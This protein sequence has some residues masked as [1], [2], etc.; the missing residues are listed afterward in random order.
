MID[1]RWTSQP[2]KF[3]GVHVS[4]V[5]FLPV[6]MFASKFLPMWI[7]GLCFVLYSVFLILCKR[8]DMDPIKYLISLEV[9]FIRRGQWLVR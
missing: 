1:W 2:L 6:L 4:I 7:I 8:R 9:R 3:F 5:I